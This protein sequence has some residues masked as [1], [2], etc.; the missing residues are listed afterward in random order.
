MEKYLNFIVLKGLRKAG[1]LQSHMATVGLATR[2]LC[3]TKIKRPDI[4]YVPLK[5]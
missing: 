4:S 2:T 5:Q 1:S 3:S